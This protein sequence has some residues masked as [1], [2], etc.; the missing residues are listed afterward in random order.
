MKSQCM[1]TSLSASTCPLLFLPNEDGCTI[2]S[3]SSPPPKWNG[4]KRCEVFSRW[5]EL[6]FSTRQLLPPNQERMGW[7]GTFRGQ[8]MAG[9]VYAYFVEVVL[10]DGRVETMKG[11]WFW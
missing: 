7:D 11:R 3:L 9:G 5:G 8:Q 2:S 10:I 1:L 6:V 4:F